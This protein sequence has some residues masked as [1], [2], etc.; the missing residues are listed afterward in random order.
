MCAN[1]QLAEA[2]AIAVST[3]HLPSNRDFHRIVMDQGGKKSKIE[4]LVVRSYDIQ[5][6]FASKL[7]RAKQKLN[8]WLTPQ[9]VEEYGT[10][11]YII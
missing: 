7:V 1:D 2:A 10:L 4:V 3:S 9:F 5:F 8:M 6:M 11:Y